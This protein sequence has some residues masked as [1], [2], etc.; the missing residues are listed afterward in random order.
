VA[1]PLE[2]R[3]ERVFPMRISGEKETG[4]IEKRPD[5]ECRP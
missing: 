4:R 2:E 1:I 5:E 3:T